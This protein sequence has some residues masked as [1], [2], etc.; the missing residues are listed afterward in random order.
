MCDCYWDECKGCGAKV[1]LHIG[2]YSTLQELVE[3]YCPNCTRKL[4]KHHK[5]VK[6]GWPERIGDQRVFV[7]EASFNEQHGVWDGSGPSLQEAVILC[8]DEGAYG[9]NFN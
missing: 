3:A 4:A 2:D 8:N 5:D 7:D 6:K 1:S 9:L